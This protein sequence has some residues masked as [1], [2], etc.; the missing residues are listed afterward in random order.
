MKKITLYLLSL[1]FVGCFLNQS[2][3]QIKPIRAEK[4]EIVRKVGTAF[5]EYREKSDV[6]RVRPSLPIYLEGDNR[7]SSSLS[8]KVSFEVKGKKV[9]TPD[10]IKIVFDSRH[11]NQRLA[12][13]K[14]RTVMLF[15]NEQKLGS[16][17]MTLFYS[18]K[19]WQ[20]G[21][22]E[23][24][25]YSLDFLYFKKFLEST[26]PEMSLGDNKLRISDEQLEMLRDMI[27]AIEE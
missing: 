18:E 13:D 16:W 22:W 4:T 5:V 25:D 10:A 21:Y 11:Q 9:I 23:V 15:D 20:G 26:K 27:R 17:V 2:N 1:A 12:K 7:S 3:A 19:S 6:T 14:N 24:V 8:L